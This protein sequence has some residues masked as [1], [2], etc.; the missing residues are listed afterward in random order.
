MKIIIPCFQYPG[1]DQDILEKLFTYTLYYIP[2]DWKYKTIVIKSGDFNIRGASHYSVVEKPQQSHW[3]NLNEVIRS[4]KDDFLIIDSDTLILN[5]SIISEVEQLLKTNDIV[6]C[7][8]NSG[9]D[10]PWTQKH[11][12]LKENDL[13]ERRGRFTPYFFASRRGLFD[14]DFDFTPQGDYLDSMSKITDELLSKNPVIEELPDDRWT[15]YWN[16]G[17][18]KWSN[19]SFDVN[20]KFS[21]VPKYSTGFY[22][23]RNIGQ[24]LQAQTALWTDLDEWQR[25]KNIVPKDELIRLMSWYNII[26]GDSMELFCKEMQIDI[27]KFTEYTNLMRP[28]L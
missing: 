7:T 3:Q 1:V 18:F 2:Y 4:I 23:I 27:D 5:N 14:Y 25:I 15:L 21:Q 10:K 24:A 26:S 17:D 12:F 6:S 19:F 16:D 20:K 9:S 11:S 22:H 8:D 28:Q 13:R